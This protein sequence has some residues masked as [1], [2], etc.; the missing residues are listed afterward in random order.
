MEHFGKICPCLS[1]KII[2]GNLHPAT[3]WW[4]KSFL[5]KAICSSI[6]FL[7]KHLNCFH[8][9]VRNTQEIATK[10]GA[11]M[12]CLMNLEQVLVCPF[13]DYCH[14]H[15]C[16]TV[17]TKLRSNLEFYF[18]WEYASCTLYFSVVLTAFTLQALCFW[19]LSFDSMKMLR[20]NVPGLLS[21]CTIPSIF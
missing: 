8:Q 21:V 3:R 7:G 19:G 18:V 10:L 11:S 16:Y 12:E 9:Q 20:T 6:V 1:S 4:L 14:Q 13:M 2:T 15:R 5:R 17:D